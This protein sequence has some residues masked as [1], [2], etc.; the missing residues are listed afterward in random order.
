MLSPLGGAYSGAASRTF[1]DMLAAPGSSHAN[2]KDLSANPHPRRYLYCLTGTRSGS[3]G[4]TSASVAGLPMNEINM[5]PYVIDNDGPANAMRL[6]YRHYPVGGASDEISVT[7][8]TGFDRGVSSWWL[9]TVRNSFPRAI[10]FETD[11]NGAIEAITVPA[12]GLILGIGYFGTNTT[13]DLSG[14]GLSNDENNKTGLGPD[15][16]W[17][18]F[19]G[20]YA[21]EDS[22]STTDSGNQGQ[23]FMIALR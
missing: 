22:V 10:G 15:L 20:E 16:A 18:A 17:N 11:N 3:G 7:F 12:R 14:P 1:I 21:T 23:G 8:D 19:S 5:A 4:A 2:N 6:F 9:A 13:I